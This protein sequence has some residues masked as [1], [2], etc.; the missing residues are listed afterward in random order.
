MKKVLSLLLMITLLLSFTAGLTISVYADDRRTVSLNAGKGT[1]S[2]TSIELDEDGT[3]PELPTPTRTGWDFVG[4]YTAEVVE[5][6]WGDEESENVDDRGAALKE[7]YSECF[8]D[9]TEWKEMLYSWIIVSDGKEVKAG[10][11]LGE[12]VTTLYAKYEP[13][14]VKVTWH[15]NGW[16]KADGVALTAYPQYDSPIT[17]LDL[18]TGQY[19]CETEEGYDGHTF[20][21]WYDSA[22]DGTKWEFTGANGCSTQRLTGD[23]DLYAYWSGGKETDKIQ[24]TPATLSAMHPGETFTLNVSYSGVQDKEINKPVVSWQYD[25]AYIQLISANDLTAEFKVL[26]TVDVTEMNKLVTITANTTNDTVSDSKDVTVR[27]IWGG[28]Q[29]DHANCVEEVYKYTCT[30]PDCGAVRYVS[31]PTGGEHT[32]VQDDAVEPTCTE[33]GKTA[34]SHCS[35][36]GEIIVAQES[37]DMIPHEFGEWEEKDGEKTRS[38]NVCGYTETL[39]AD[40]DDPGNQPPAEG[41]ATVEATS[42]RYVVGSGSGAVIQLSDPIEELTGVY[43]NGELVDEA[44][45]TLSEDGM[46]LTFTSEYLDELAAGEYEVTLLTAAGSVST[47]LTVE[48]AVDDEAEAEEPAEDVTTDEPTAETPK[49]DPATEAPEEEPSTDD[50]A[51]EAPEEEPTAEAPKDEPIAEAPVTEA[52]KEEATTKAPSTETAAKE[53]TAKPDTADKG[54]SGKS[55]STG[56]PSKGWLALAAIALAG[57]AAMI[58]K[59]KEEDQ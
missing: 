8:S 36:C 34:G 6:Y 41:E 1:I 32:I 54:N 4:W 40:T 30:Y 39:P 53:E 23:L 20:D 56:A 47:S 50:T 19:S 24:I 29:F 21:G 49:D 35:V 9:D 33:T 37:I 15:F 13:T 43:V 31:Y 57:G 18:T 26:E 11:Q 27:H 14:T 46:V 59:K 44:N 22:E 12:D 42:A 52:N 55:P 2:E 25:N 5:N 58:V 10:D 48:K 28:A 7:K 45:Y 16:H 38:C 3:L 17:A 51:A